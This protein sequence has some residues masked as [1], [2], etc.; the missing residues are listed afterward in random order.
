MDRRTFLSS[1]VVAGGGLL[2]GCSQDQ[3]DP[4][5]PASPEATSPGAEGSLDD[6]IAQVAPD[7]EQNLSVITGSFEQLT[8]EAVPFAFG[9][10]TIENEPV[11]GADF[12]LYVAPPEGEPSGPYPAEFR[13]VPAQPLGI[14]VSQ[15]DLEQTG[16]T[17][18][19]VVTADGSRAGLAALQIRTPEESPLPAPGAQAPAVATPTTADPMGMAQLCT[20]SPP[21]GMHEISLDQALRE[22]RPVAITFAT[23]AYCQT[24]VCGPS[25]AAL[26]EVRSER[27]WGDIA[28]IHV[29]IYSDEGVTVADPV[30]EWELP[31][32]P[33]LFTIGGD[34]SIQGRADGPLLVLPDQLTSLLEKV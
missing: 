6:L 14:Y 29:E 21:C 10:T 18:F 30:R 7:A 9:V 16:P 4:A 32:E 20:Q 12:D 5:A 27:D 13:E 1:L 19:I 26:E 2:V 8:G 22:G 33:W 23:P 3:A 11:T 17:S 34:G 15:V 28:F 31:S 24:A 25:V